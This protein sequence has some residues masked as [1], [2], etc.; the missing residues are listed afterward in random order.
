VLP[1]PQAQASTIAAS[2][3]SNL[4]VLES[5]GREDGFKLGGISLLGAISKVSDYYV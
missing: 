3:L 4:A 2:K 1:P 5:L